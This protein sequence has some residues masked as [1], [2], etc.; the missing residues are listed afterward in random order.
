MLF[1]RRVSLRAEPE[2]QSEVRKMSRDF[3]G[4]R[5]R[6]TD[7]SNTISNFIPIGEDCQMFFLFIY[8]R[9]ISVKKYKFSQE[10][11]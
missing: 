1:S 9:F 7:D 6:K 2:D 8:R 10:I 3:R 4:R 5:W 11:K